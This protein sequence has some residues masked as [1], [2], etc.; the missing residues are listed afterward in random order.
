MKRARKPHQFAEDP[1]PFVVIGID[2]EWVYE[3]AGKNLILSY[4]FALLNDDTE[5]M[6]RLIEYPNNGLRMSLERGLTRLMLKAR[7]ERVIN[8]VPRRFIIAGHFTRADLTTFFG[9]W[10]VQAAHQRSK[11]NLCDDRTAAK[12]AASSE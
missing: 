12:P 3:S 2:A 6:T 1:D 9:F 10:F 5:E 4:Q 7:Q 8:T 11:K